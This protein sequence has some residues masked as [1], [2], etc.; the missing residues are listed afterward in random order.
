MLDYQIVVPSRKRPFNMPVL[1]SLLPTA[2]ICVDERE[3]EDYAPYV[4]ADQLLIHPP[5]TG[6]PAARNWIIDNVSSPILVM[7]DD[8]LMGVKSLVGSKRTITD[9]DEILAIIENAARV[10][11]D[12]DVST[13]CW[14]RTANDFLLRPEYLPIRPVQPVYGCFGFR[15]PA[16]YRKYDETLRSRGDLDWTM[17]TLLE[18]RF[19]YADVRFYFDFG[20]SFT[21][22]GGNTGLVQPQEFTDA[23]REVKRRWGCHIQYKAPGFVKT[24][25]IAP[26]SIRVS[27][28]N[29]TAKR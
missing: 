23:S 18:D 14:S 7:C 28:T 25:E 27:R 26:A 5:T 22:S 24:R 2:L 11:D 4:P 15:G 13:F 29:K 10:A 9:P 12:L 16:R 21:G 19:V 6:A 8:D 1:K 17:R 20:T 3:R